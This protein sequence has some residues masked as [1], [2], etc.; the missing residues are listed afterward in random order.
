MIYPRRALQRRL[1][2]LRNVLDEGVVDKLA[3]RLNRAG[4]DRTAAMWEVVVLHGL[5]KCGTLHHEVALASGRRPDIGFERTALRFIA[6]VT[7]VSDDGLDKDNPYRELRDLI[8]SAK[9][10][11]NLPI[12]GLDLTVRAKHNYTKRGIHTVLML[13]PRAKLQEFVRKTIV[14]RLREQI[15]VGMQVLRLAIDDDDIGLDITI[16]PAKSPYSSGSFAAYDVPKIKDRNP[17]YRA[18]KN[19]ADQL[20]GAGEL[21]GVIVGDGG[22][23][24][25]SGRSANWDEVSTRKITAEFFRQFSSVDFV[26]LLSI[27][28]T[29]SGWGPIPQLVRRNDASLHVRDG[30]AAG[31]ALDNV[32]RTLAEHFPKPAMMPVNGALRAREDGYYVGHHGGYKM[33]GSKVQIGLREFTEI[34]AGLRTLQDNGAK[35][36]EAARKLCREPNRVQ[37]TI[38]RN[39]LEGRL[40]SSIEIIKTDEDHN[41]DWVEIHFGEIDPA[42][43]PLR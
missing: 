41:D 33:S 35:N 23:V 15:D 31:P 40:P 19:K 17:L 16:D 8:E 43:A 6:D 3:A 11:L 36:V 37:A 9:R 25:L 39:L 20:Q 14:P 12:G 26:L 2:E 34:F 18:L 4:K 10:K 21:T 42:I 7:A 24:A 22:C 28:E 29:R 32:F 13:P 1:N 5:S 30:C 38:V 27:R